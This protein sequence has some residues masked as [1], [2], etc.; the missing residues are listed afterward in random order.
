MFS[1]EALLRGSSDERPPQVRIPFPIT[2]IE[3]SSIVLRKT[4]TTR[5]VQGISSESQT[6]D[7][8]QLPGRD[9]NGYPPSQLERGG[10]SY[11]TDCAKT[12]DGG[13]RCS[14]GGV[15]GHGRGRSAARL[16]GQCSRVSRHH[17][18]P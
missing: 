5:R 3:H 15:A 17:S 11:E 8:L 18:R 9:E 14:S 1:R 12:T 16:S 10:L 6:A 13:E 7:K 4:P 2:Q